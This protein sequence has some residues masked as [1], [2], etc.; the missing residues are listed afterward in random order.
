MD[1][2]NLPFRLARNPCFMMIAYATWR[3]Y[4]WTVHIGGVMSVRIRSAD[5]QSRRPGLVSWPLTGCILA[6]EGF[7]PG[8]HVKA[9][10][11]SRHYNSIFRSI[12]SVVEWQH[13]LI[14]HLQAS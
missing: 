10:A 7:W 4:R 5:Q 11:K 13:R 8:D 9:A 2:T 1:D 3:A 12:C 6:V 14:T